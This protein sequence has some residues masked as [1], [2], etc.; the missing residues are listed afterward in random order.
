MVEE[1]TSASFSLSEETAQLTSLIKQFRVDENDS[2][3]TLRHEL[4]KVAPHAF[5]TP[6]V[7]PDRGR[8]S[9]PAIVGIVNG[10]PADK[11]A[12]SL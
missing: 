1:S 9:P 6:V 7:A 12:S 8:Q 5:R 10:A 2:G 3:D 4:R 11:R